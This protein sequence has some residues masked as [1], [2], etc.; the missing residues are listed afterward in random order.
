VLR[1][2]H[3]AVFALGQNENGQLGLG[4]VGGAQTAAAATPQRCPIDE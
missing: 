3:G 1:D 4:G 2:E